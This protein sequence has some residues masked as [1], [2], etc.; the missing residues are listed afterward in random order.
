MPRRSHRSEPPARSTSANPK[1]R[2]YDFRVT[3]GGT[4]YLVHPLNKHAA[5]HLKENVQE[6]AQWMGDALAVEHR[7]IVDLIIALRQHGYEVETP[8]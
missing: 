1:P 3:G 2:V 6:D 4:I 8:Q 7:Y 5:K